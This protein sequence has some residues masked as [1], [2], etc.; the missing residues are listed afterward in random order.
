MP[1]PIDRAFT[2]LRAFLSPPPPAPASVPVD[3][4]TRPWTSPTKEQAQAILRARTESLPRRRLI[5]APYGIRL[6]RPVAVRAARP[7]PAWT[8]IR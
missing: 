4:W 6:E 1:N 5:I 3:P 7:G 2:R 8:W